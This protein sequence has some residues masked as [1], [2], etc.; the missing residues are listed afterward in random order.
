MVFHGVL[1]ASL[2]GRDCARKG[3]R[4]QPLCPAGSPASVH[5]DLSAEPA[6]PEVKAVNKPKTNEKHRSNV[7]NSGRVLLESGTRSRRRRKARE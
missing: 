7:G 1:V 2:F 3:L 4:L 6:A 5:R